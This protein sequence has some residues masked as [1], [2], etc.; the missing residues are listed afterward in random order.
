[1]NFQSG[2]FKLKGITMSLFEDIQAYKELFILSLSS[3][4]L[5]L[6]DPSSKNQGSNT[7]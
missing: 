5:N 6:I 4:V 1:M 7:N 3:I 2:E